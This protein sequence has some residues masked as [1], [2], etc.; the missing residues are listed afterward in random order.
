MMFCLLD[1]I[2][3]TRNLLLQVFRNKRAIASLISF[4]SINGNKKLQKNDSNIELLYIAGTG[5][6]K[7]HVA[8]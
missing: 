1:K 6:I 2:F 8:G 5:A 3:N 4:L 7:T